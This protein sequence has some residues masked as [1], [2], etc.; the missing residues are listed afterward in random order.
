MAEAQN[1]KQ[2]LEL[3][4]PV[5]DVD[6]ETERAVESLKK[7]V[8]IPGFRPGKVP[9]DLIR[10]RFQEDIRQEVLDKLL[11]KHFF[12]R[13]EEEGLA[14]VGTP[15]IT[16]VHFHPG[17][18]LRF[19]AEFE[20]APQFELKD[21]KGVEVK[22]S[23]PEVSDEEIDKRIDAIREQKAEFVAI[24]PR[25]A[26]DGD[27]AVLSLNSLAGVNPPINQDEVTLLIGGEETLAGFS[28]NLRGMNPGEEKDFDVLYPEDY[29]NEKIAGKTVRFHAA[30]KVLRKKE[31]PELN[32]E[33]AGDVGDFKNL[34]EL[35]EAVRTAIFTERQYVAQQEAKN[36]IVDALVEMHDFPVPDA[37]IERQ[38]ESQVERHLHELAAQGV[39]PSKVKLDWAKIKE[40]QRERAVKDV[41]ASLLVH[42]IADAE[43]IHATNDE[44]DKEVARFARQEREPVAAVRMRLEKEGGLGRIAARIRTEKALSFLFEQARKVAE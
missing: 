38:I 36:K 16:E 31:L 5:V 9:T 2:T 1:L 35:R 24:E 22:Y 28:E 3:T 4:V 29:G 43:Q 25:P 37:Y 18:P 44:V 39:D 27:Y 14:V 10:R 32:D 41:K 33:F 17:E 6:S 21:Y 11:P 15:S 42:R 40:S 26:E 19:K 12:K 8:R 30:L 23:E 34:G 13:A 7:R 20:V